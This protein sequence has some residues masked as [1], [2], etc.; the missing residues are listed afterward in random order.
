MSNEINIR[1]ECIDP[2]LY[3]KD[4]ARSLAFYVDILGFKKA[5]WG[6]DDFTSINRD[7]TGLYLCKGGQGIPGTWIWRTYTDFSYGKPKWQ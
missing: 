3:V 2:I 5:D 1:M 7:N 6:N 4:M